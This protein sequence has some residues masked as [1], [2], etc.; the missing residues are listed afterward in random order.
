MIALLIHSSTVGADD[1][2]WRSHANGRIRTVRTSVVPPALFLEAS[3][4]STTRAA[5]HRYQA[6]LVR[7]LLATNDIWRRLRESVRLRADPP[8]HIAG[9]RKCSF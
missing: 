8:R 4:R 3:L 9:L 2:D 1:S 7:G 6:I 5:T